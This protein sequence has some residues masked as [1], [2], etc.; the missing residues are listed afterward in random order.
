[1]SE[2][3]SLAEAR[4]QP[5]LRLVA[6]R[7]FPSPWTQAA[8]GILHIKKIPHALCA[9]GE[10]EG[11]ADLVEWTR[12]AS[13]PV[14]MYEDEAPRSGWAEI[15]L[16]AERL[17][18]E[19]SLLPKDPARRALHFGIAHEICGEMGLGWCRRL[20]AV[21]AGYRS[22]PPAPMA[23]WL[24]AKYGYRPD[25]AAVA[26]SRVVEVLGL[27]DQTLREGGGEYLLGELTAADVYWATF[28]NLLAPLP[29]EKMPMNEQMRATFTAREPAVLAAL[30]PELVALRDRV[31]E[32]HL[33]LPVL[34]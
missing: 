19:P 10:G 8:K 17:A 6:M 12:Q 13:Y 23:V 1:M 9:P 20:C 5:G 26:E 32:R 27:L 30:T 11:E 4:E 34:L 31:Y 29:Q 14:A 22:D 33:V 16:L 18:P 7:G 28:C 21:A 25:S 3:L 15:L 24:G 2:S